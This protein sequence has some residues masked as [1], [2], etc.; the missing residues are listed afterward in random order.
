MVFAKSMEVRDNFKAWCTQVS[1]GETIQIARPG[2]NYVYLM[3]QETYERLT[4]ERRAAAYTS[5]LYGKDK[6]I[7]L[8]WLSEIE[9]LPDYWN[10][11]GAEKIAKNIIK[12]VRKLLMRLEHQPEIFPTACD[13]IQL[14]WENENKEY[15]EMEIL[16]DSINVFQ[17]DSEGGEEQKTIAIDHSAVEQIVRG[18]YERTV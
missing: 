2:N 3:G 7:N 1:E 4:M 9:K 8:K 18:F 11:N 15:L 12:N 6:I 10:N 17:I 5:Y 13:A 14:E 16:E